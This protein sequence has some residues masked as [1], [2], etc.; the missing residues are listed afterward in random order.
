[1]RDNMTYFGRDVGETQPAFPHSLWHVALQHLVASMKQYLVPNHVDQV[2]RITDHY[3]LRQPD[4]A[5]VLTMIYSTQPLP[6]TSIYRRYFKIRNTTLIIILKRYTSKAVTALHGSTNVKSPP[7][8]AE[9]H[10]L[11]DKVYYKQKVRLYILGQFV[12]WQYIPNP[13][14]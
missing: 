1:M 3:L 5:L 14:D 13:L 8:F 6:H 9:I 7:T 2:L 12:T 11:W 4:F 10:C